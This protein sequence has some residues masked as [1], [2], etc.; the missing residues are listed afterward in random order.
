M[1]YEWR[2]NRLY[3][4]GDKPCDLSINLEGQD[5]HILYL[6]PLVIRDLVRVS[7][8][9]LNNNRDITREFQNKLN[10]YKASLISSKLSPMEI[11]KGYLAFWWPSIKF[12]APALT[13]DLNDD[14]LRS[15]YHKLLP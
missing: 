12:M 9:P 13:L 11:M 1:S 3:L 10:T 7:T 5:Q 6:S 14:I 8:N 4:K 15:F 2:N